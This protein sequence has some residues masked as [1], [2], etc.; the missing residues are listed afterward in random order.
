MIQ[1][2][3]SELLVD[4]AIHDPEGALAIFQKIFQRFGYE[5]SP[6]LSLEVM[7]AKKE[8]NE[9]VEITVYDK[10]GNRCWLEYGDNGYIDT[11]GYRFDSH[12]SD[13][14]SGCYPIFKAIIE[15]AAGQ[16]YSC[17]G[18]HTD[19]YEYWLKKQRRKR[20]VNSG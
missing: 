15:E 17:D 14:D 1:T 10:D 13:Y 18:G 12:C 20:N 7:E 9:T 16:L 4:T 2:S 3:C 19:G 8:D 6:P 5:S 11:L